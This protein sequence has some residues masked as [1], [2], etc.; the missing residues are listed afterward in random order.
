IDRKGVVCLEKQ[1]NK[2]SLLFLI[3][4]FLCFTFITFLKSEGKS[5]FSLKTIHAEETSLPEKFAPNSEYL[6]DQWNLNLMNIGEAWA[7][8]YDGK[9]IKIAVLDT[10]FYHKHPDIELAGGDSVFS[11]EAWSLDHS[12]H[13][14]HIAGIISAQSTSKYQGLAPGAEVY[15]IKI[16][17]SEDIDEFGDVSTDV[18]SVTKG[19]KLAIDK[20]TDIIVISSGLDYHD[21][22]LYQVIQEAHNNNIM[23]I[24][25]SGNGNLSV[26]YPASYNEVVAVTA[27]DE[28]LNPALDIIYGEENELTAPGVNIGGLSIPDSNYSYPYIY[29]SGSSQATPHV[30]SLAAIF[31]QKYNIRGEEAREMMQEKAIDIGDSSLFG[32]GLAYYQTNQ[33][34]EKEDTIK[35][36]S[37]NN[38]KEKQNENDKEENIEARKPSSSREADKKEDDVDDKLSEHKKIRVSLLEEKEA[39]IDQSEFPVLEMGGKLDIFMRGASSLK[40]TESQIADIRQ[41]NITITLRQEGISWEIPPSNFAPGQA[42]LRFYKGQPLGTEEKVSEYSNV[43]TIS[44][45][46]PQTRQGVYPGWMKITFDLNKQKMPAPSKLEAAQFDKSQAEWLVLEKKIE[47]EQLSLKTKFT[48]AL[49]VFEV[50]TEKNEEK[51]TN[52]KEFFSSFIIVIFIGVPLIILIFIIHIWLSKKNSAIK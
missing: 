13:G 16:Y 31:M 14:T 34:N 20:E 24:A 10:G 2:K 38:D 47:E 25:A 32:Y 18:N 28:D 41:K 19:V 45:F 29:M 26:N 11:D 35:T 52:T 46:Q 17:H 48:G 49:G 3:F 1:K 27:I 15:G 33:E 36:S 21:E 39:V 5:A 40:L 8:G 30:A 43:Y 23:I 6:Q 37:E 12:G 44:I 51:E 22:E 4:I 50:N 42:Q 9:G 7:D